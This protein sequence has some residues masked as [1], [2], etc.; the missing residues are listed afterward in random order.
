MKKTLSLILA[1]LLAISC[2]SFVFADDAEEATA[3]EAVVAIAEEPAGSPYETAVKFLYD[4]KVYKGY[5]E[6]DLGTENDVKRYEMALF[7]ARISTGWVDDDQWEDGD[8]NN[9]GFTDLAGT[10]ADSYLGAISYASQKGIIEGYGNGKF[11][12]EDGITYQDALTMT[13]RTLGYEG[14]SY[15]WGYIEKA[16]A[17]G[18]TKGITGVAYT[19]KLNRGVVAQIIYNALYAATADGSKLLKD[20]FDIEGNDVWEKVL[21]TATSLATYHHDDE[22]TKAGVIGFRRLAAD[23]TPTG[24]TYYVTLET[25]GF[26]NVQDATV[27]IGRPYEVIFNYAKDGSVVNVKEVQQILPLNVI[28]NSADSV[29]YLKKFTLVDR[30][31]AISVLDITKNEN[32]QGLYKDEF[33][34]MTPGEFF[35]STYLFGINWETGDIVAYNSATRGY[36]TMWYYNPILGEYYRYIIQDA[37]GSQGKIV[38]GYEYMTAAEADALK[39]MTI[40]WGV[41]EEAYGTTAEVPA[42]AAYAT[43]EVYDLTGDGTGDYG[44]YEEYYFGKINFKAKE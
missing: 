32:T 31:T 6:N 23:G 10:P 38:V 43:L 17:L 3:E 1:L 13:V 44:F 26:A 27:Q 37:I 25:F 2:A 33:M 22:R 18:L 36:D 29:K 20:S 24:A 40:D 11:G 12:P 16:V 41:E 30:F 21:L 4:L 14:L 15:P 34:L 19:T 39:Q 42:E 7:V 35:D 5:N 28:D 9:S 8:A